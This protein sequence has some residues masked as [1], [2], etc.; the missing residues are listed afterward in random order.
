MK[1]FTLKVGALAVAAALLGLVS[2]QE[3][4][5]NYPPPAGSAALSGSSTTASVGGDVVL[6]LTLVDSTGSPIAGKACT[7][8]ISSQPGIDA[9]VTQDS[10]TT[11]A[12]GVIT[13]SLY[14]GTAPGIVQVVANC[15]NLFAGFS[16]AVAGVAAAPPQAPVEP[17]QITLPPTGFSPAGGSH[18]PDVV[19]ALL[20]G[21]L[22]ALSTGSALLVTGRVRSGS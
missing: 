2:V 21:G 13:A 14:A 9:T 7:M 22:L 10:A 17:T 4:A 16:A 5:A 12:D 20:C 3:T 11:D 1:W 15:G 6:T 19:L 18:S 8:Y